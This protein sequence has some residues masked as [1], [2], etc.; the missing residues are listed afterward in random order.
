[1]VFVDVFSAFAGVYAGYA[2][3]YR[4]KFAGIVTVAKDFADKLKNYGYDR[5]VYATGRAFITFGR[6]AA[7]FDDGLSSFYSHMASGSFFLSSSSRKIQSGDAQTY[8]IAIF[9]GLLAIMAV[10]AA[11]I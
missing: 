7:K 10:A 2:M 4:L 8:I 9:I 11:I 6:A 1:M 3:F 5:Y